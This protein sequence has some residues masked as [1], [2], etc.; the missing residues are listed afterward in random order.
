MALAFGA[1]A[2]SF[3]NVCIYRLPRSC[4]R[5][6]RPKG[7][8]CPACGSAIRAIHNVPVLSWLVLRGRCASCKAPIRFRYPAVEALTALL[9]LVVVLSRV[10]LGSPTGWRGSVALA[11]DVYMVCAVVV[12]SFVDHDLHIIPDEISLAGIPI[13]LAASMVAP[14][15]LQ[16][17]GLPV[18]T[19]SLAL[20]GL[21][22]AILGGLAGG[23]T[24]WLVGFLGRVILRREAM[25]LGDVKLLAGFG[26]LVGWQGTIAVIFGAGLAAVVVAGARFPFTRSHHLAFGPYLAG[27]TLVVRVLDIRLT[28]R[29]LDLLEWVHQPGRYPWFM[30]ALFVM[31]AGML[32]FLVALRR[33]QRA[34]EEDQVGSEQIS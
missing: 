19:G 22:S 33:D 4:M 28:E 12:L 26:A 2:G 10:D 16:L 24:L 23:G 30:G 6:D 8:H 25:G 1:C 21:V 29:A 27:A 17:A 5:I 7:S 11:I 34:R 32:A 9:F 20:D 18:A 13:A 15:E 31:V 14:T 3:L